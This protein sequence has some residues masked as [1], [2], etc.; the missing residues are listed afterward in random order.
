MRSG[1][2]PS[3]G[4]PVV[5][6]SLSGQKSARWQNGPTNERNM[7]SERAS[8]RARGLHFSQQRE[9]EAILFPRDSWRI[10]GRPNHETSLD[11][12]TTYRH[13]G[14]LLSL[15]CLVRMRQARSFK[16]SKF[17]KEAGHCLFEVS[18]SRTEM[19]LSIATRFCDCY[20]PVEEDVISNIRN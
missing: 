4:P 11:S 18:F 9:R 1:G 5:R 13:P 2:R 10:R 6:L 15:R 14:D 20:R 8:E 19:G 3:A 17:P 16:S 7:A 12:R